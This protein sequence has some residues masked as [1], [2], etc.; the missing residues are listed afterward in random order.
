VEIGSGYG[1]LSRGL[2]AM[3]GLGRPLCVDKRPWPNVDIV[4]DLE[5][6]DM[7]PLVEQLR[8][9]DVIVASEFL[10][11]VTNGSE[12]LNELSS[13]PVLV[14]EFDTGSKLF[15]ASFVLQVA[16]FGGDPVSTSNL[17]EQFGTRK[18]RVVNIHPYNLFLLERRS[19]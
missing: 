10:H 7:K 2:S 16:K 18:W 5:Y 14:L 1:W 4:L 3:L 12:I 13:W 19:A 6:E 11:C 15:G 8:D 17:T 9:G